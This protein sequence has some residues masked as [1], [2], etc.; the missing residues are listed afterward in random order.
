MATYLKDRAS[1]IELAKFFQSAHLIKA[2][3]IQPAFYCIRKLYGESGDG[4]SSLVPVLF[5]IYR[6]VRDRNQTRNCQTRLCQTIGLACVRQTNWTSLCQTI[7]LAIVRQTT[8]TS[9]CHTT[10]TSLCQTNKLDQPTILCQTI[11]LA[12]VRQTNKTTLCQTIGLDCVSQTSWTNLCQTIGLACVTQ[13]IWTNLCQTN[14]LYQPRWPWPQID[15]ISRA[16]YE[17]EEDC[18]TLR[19]ELK[20]EHR[21][22]GADRSS[23]FFLKVKGL[24]FSITKEGGCGGFGC[25]GW[26]G[27]GVG[28]GDGLVVSS[29]ALLGLEPRTH[30]TL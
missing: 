23:I 18:D 10:W 5:K 2:L 1:P 19:W 15:P 3:W 21:L 6:E 7:R 22:A 9:L 16:R 13:T 25:D 11:G 27:V 20:Q 29:K 24:S 28:T 4:R 12:C 26:T 17:Y 8:L 14:K 30:L